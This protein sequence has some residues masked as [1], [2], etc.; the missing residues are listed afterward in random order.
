MEVTLINKKSIEARIETLANEINKDYQNRLYNSREYSDTVKIT[1]NVLFVGT[2]NLDESTYHFSDKV[3]DRANVI[4]LKLRK[5]KEVAQSAEKSNVADS[6]GSAAF[7]KTQF[8]GTD[9]L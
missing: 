3:L 7:T 4:H 9:F 5:F 8:F 2:V 6:I 1:D